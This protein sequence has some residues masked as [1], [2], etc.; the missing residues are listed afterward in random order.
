MKIQI[1]VV[2]DDGAI[3]RGEATLKRATGKPIRPIAATSVK[4]GKTNCPAA[5]GEL[6]RKGNFKS[7]LSFSDI[8]Q[9]LADG[10]FNFPDNTLM[11]A[12]AAA[13]YLTRRGAKGSYTWSQRHPYNG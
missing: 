9:E 1:E 4:P 3:F 11:M 10:G 13:K 5:I 7:A 8:K 12:L 2:A 6:W